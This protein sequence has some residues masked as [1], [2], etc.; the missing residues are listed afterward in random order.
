MEYFFDSSADGWLSPLDALI[1]INELN[2]AGHG[3]SESRLMPLSIMA[4]DNV[5]P[6]AEV[7]DMALLVL[8]MTFERE[9]RL[10][11]GRR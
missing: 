10:A 3:E 2:S 5:A 7:H 4:D 1:I 6:D 11:A 8:L 9:R